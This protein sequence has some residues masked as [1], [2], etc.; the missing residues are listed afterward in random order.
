MQ[1]SGVIEPEKPSKVGE[2]LVDTPAQSLFECLLDT[3]RKSRCLQ[4]GSQFVV[5]VA[6]GSG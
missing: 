5:E 3:A 6:L 4:Q 1:P 2:F